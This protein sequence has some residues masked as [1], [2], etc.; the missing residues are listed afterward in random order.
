MNNRSSDVKEVKPLQLQDRIDR[1]TRYVSVEMTDETLGEFL[2]RHGA[3]LLAFCAVNLETYLSNKATYSGLSRQETLG[4][5]ANVTPVS[6]TTLRNCAQSYSRNVEEFAESCANISGAPGLTQ[7]KLPGGLTMSATKC[8]SWNEIAWTCNE[9]YGL[10]VSVGELA[11]LNADSAIAYVVPRLPLIPES[12]SVSHKFTP[13]AVDPIQELEA[14]IVVRRP[15]KKVSPH[16]PTARE[17]VSPVLPAIYV[18]AAET[19]LTDFVTAFEVAL[20]GHALAAGYRADGRRRLYAIDR[21]R[22]GLDTGSLK[23][24]APRRYGLPPLDLGRGSILASLRSVKEGTGLLEGQSWLRPAEAA[25]MRGSLEHMF[26]TIERLLSPELASKAYYFAADRLQ[27]IVMAKWTLAKNLGA[28][29][30][31]TA[32]DGKSGAD[33]LATA[34]ERYRHAL[35]RD[36]R[37]A[38]RLDGIY[39]FPVTV[40]AAWTDESKK[41]LVGMPHKPIVVPKDAQSLEDLETDLKVNGTALANAL[42]DV[43][44]ILDVGKL[45]KFRGRAITIERRH[46]LRSLLAELGAPSPERVDGDDLFQ[47]P[48]LFK[49]GA[50]L[51][52]EI[53]PFDL[54]PDDT[55]ASLQTKLRLPFYEVVLNTKNLFGIFGEPKPTSLDDTV[56]NLATVA[57]AFAP[58]SDILKGLVSNAPGARQDAE[59]E[60][61]KAVG[62]PDN[63][64]VHTLKIGDDIVVFPKEASAGRDLV[65]WH[66]ANPQYRSIFSLAEAARDVKLALNSKIAVV[67]RKGLTLKDIAKQFAGVDEAVI[68]QLMA[69]VSG[70]LYRDGQIA[71]KESSWKKRATGRPDSDPPKLRLSRRMTLRDVARRLGFKDFDEFVSM[72]TGAWQESLELQ[73]G[74]FEPGIE[75]P[76][77][78]VALSALGT[79]ERQLTLGEVADGAGLSAANLLL[80]LPNVQKA[81]FT[82]DATGAMVLKTDINCPILVPRQAAPRLVGTLVAK[83][84][85]L[86]APT[87]LGP[88]KISLVSGASKINCPVPAAALASLPTKGTKLEAVIDQIEYDI[89]EVDDTGGYQAS[90]WLRL[91]RP[92]LVAVD[93]SSMA[94]LQKDIPVAMR[95]IKQNSE[96]CLTTSTAQ[97]TLET[98]FQASPLGLDTYEGNIL[99]NGAVKPRTAIVLNALAEWSALRTEIN[100]LLIAMLAPA[101]ISTRISDFLAA[102]ADIIETVA[103]NWNELR[104][105]GND[106]HGPGF[107]LQLAAAEPA[108][109][110]AAVKK[111]TLVWTPPVGEN[112]SCEIGTRSLPDGA[113]TTIATVTDASSVN[114]GVD[115]KAGVPREFRACVSELKLMERPDATMTMRAWRDNA[116]GAVKQQFVPKLGPLYFEDPAQP[117]LLIEQLSIVHAGA[118]L[119]DQIVFIVKEAMQGATDGSSHEFEFFIDEIAPASLKSAATVRN[120]LAYACTKLSNSPDDVL[121]A[122]GD[123]TKIEGVSRDKLRCTARIWSEWRDERAPPIVEYRDV[124]LVGS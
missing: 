23:I 6:G 71:W 112:C 40:T 85:T 35:N 55:F 69:D 38:H 54:V 94:P 113:W 1:V 95:A 51:P 8:A 110:E 89:A 48:A 15:E 98:V 14:Q 50:E 66:S 4:S 42:A 30:A 97:W 119:R 58:A 33:A 46:T 26:G 39:Q 18:A 78:R 36:L 62:I 70:I 81:K 90:H 83:P 57:G 72:I 115:W 29:L 7:I 24:G 79:E 102:V 93:Q 60:I 92:H 75:L 17:T 27:K 37:E 2:S 59:A 122:L 61:R 43:V 45:A 73:G 106:G 10:N 21:K 9:A 111:A 53:E 44:G 77:T 96:L 116:N 103:E 20:P 104:K 16:C 3:S 13:G 34:S 68:M 67:R 47:I 86:A 5:A 76:I 107:T 118:G 22:V 124:R 87:V 105:L 91:F 123:L 12:F 114:I 49:P 109:D 28:D 88:I 108:G 82:L 64:E 19:S 32:Q 99:L 31:D 65:I 11:R 63:V 41:T 84:V 74:L 100:S 117:R 121:S 120:A 25:E 52:I 101:E 56:K 80:Q